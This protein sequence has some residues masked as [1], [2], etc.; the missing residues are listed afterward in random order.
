M[1]GFQRVLPQRAPC[2]VISLELRTQLRRV[3]WL[4]NHLIRFSVMPLIAM[5]LYAYRDVH[6][7]F[8]GPRKAP[9]YSRQSD[10][11]TEK[12]PLLLPTN[13][14]PHHHRNLVSIN[15]LVPPRAGVNVR[16]SYVLVL[17][18]PAPPKAASTGTPHSMSSGPA[19]RW[20]GARSLTCI[21]ENP[22]FLHAL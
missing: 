6:S 17:P 19:V 18:S 14:P 13:L 7:L 21:A 9:A 11:K 15:R 10:R 20:G 3:P 1:L 12:D 5:P 22:S 8:S 2:L 4:S 16:R